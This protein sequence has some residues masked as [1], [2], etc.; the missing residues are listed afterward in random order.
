MRI[1]HITNPQQ[2]LPPRGDRGRWL[3]VTTLVKEQVARGHEVTVFGNKKT[4]IPGAYTEAIEVLRPE[5]VKGPAT[6]PRL[7][8]IY[9]ALILLN[10]AYRH[11]DKFDILH[12]H[13]DNLHFFMSSLVDKPTLMT[14]HWPIEELTQNIVKRV[15]YSNVY[16]TP[17]SRAQTRHQS[18]R[19]QY[20]DVVYNGIDINQ[21][22]FVAKPQDHLAFIGRLH[23]S[24]GAHH[25]IRVCRQLKRK[26]VLA[27]STDLQREV[28]RLYWEKHINPALKSPY[29]TYR[30]ELSHFRQV[31]KFM[32]KAKALLFPIDWEEPFGLVMVEAMAT[33]TP[34][35]AY[36][37]GSV[38]EL[39]KDGV[40]G[41]IVKNEDEM[42][43][44]IKKIDTI[45]R[46]ACRKWVTDRF[47]TEK[48]VD[49][50][51]GVYK[52]LIKQ[53]AK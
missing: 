48:M 24:K 6:S 12:C 21:F 29:I 22:A 33:G 4:N 36:N 52:K 14:Q 38:P 28:Y 30:G 16:I 8:K 41:F 11:I 3:L 2:V 17:I 18:E 43:R 13:F 26:L 51:E 23:P 5:K 44:A 39:V 40:T 25:A 50:Y 9:N 15:P 10:K 19:I 7:L 46:T 37:R 31:P 49:G 47:T 20:T 53:H 34:V 32:G 1:A 45:D 35:I 27:G 42:K